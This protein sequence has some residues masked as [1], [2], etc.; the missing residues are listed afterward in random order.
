MTKIK[1]NS[2]RIQKLPD[3]A[4]KL[5]KLSTLTGYEL[6]DGLA[7]LMKNKPHGTIETAIRELERTPSFSL[8]TAPT[9]RKAYNKVILQQHVFSMLNHMWKGETVIFRIYNKVQ[10]QI[11]QDCVDSIRDYKDLI[12]TDDDAKHFT[13]EC[14]K[15]Y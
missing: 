7:K 9:L 11:V 10:R 14:G 13:V 5:L 4:T 2:D 1:I 3:L 6:T 12:T 15:I 8:V